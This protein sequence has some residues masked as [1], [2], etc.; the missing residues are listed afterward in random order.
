DLSWFKKTRQ[1]FA[2]ARKGGSEHE[3]T[4]RKRKLT[5]VESEDEEVG[6]VDHSVEVQD[7][8]DG[9][10]AHMSHEDSG[11]ESDFVE[12]NTSADEEVTRESNKQTTS[13]GSR[14]APVEAKKTRGAKAS[15]PEVSQKGRR[16][17]RLAST[18][19]GRSSITASRTGSTTA[20]A[21]VGVR[22]RR[23]GRPMK[24]KRKPRSCHKP[25]SLDSM[26]FYRPSDKNLSTNYNHP[27]DWMHPGTPLRTQNASVQEAIN[28][29]DRELEALEF[30]EEEVPCIRCRNICDPELNLAYDMQGYCRP[31]YVK[32]MYQNP[33]RRPSRSEMLARRR[34]LEKHALSYQID[35]KRQ[36]RS[37]YWCG[38]SLKPFNVDDVAKLEQRSRIDINGQSMP[39]IPFH[40]H[41][42][43]R[44][45][46]AC[47]AELGELL[48]IKRRFQRLYALSSDF[49][50]EQCANCGVRESVKFQPGMDRMGKLCIPCH[51]Y[52]SIHGIERDIYPIS[53]HRMDEFVGAVGENTDDNGIYWDKVACE[54]GV[55]PGFGYSVEGI[56]TQWYNHF[57][58]ADAPPYQTF[59]L[60]Q[61][62]HLAK[63]D[64]DW[65]MY[66]CTAR[67]P[68]QAALYFARFTTLYKKR[69]MTHL[70]IRQVE[71]W[72][73]PKTR[74]DEWEDQSLGLISFDELRRR[75]RNYMN[76]TTDACKSRKLHA[77]HEKLRKLHSDI[78]HQKKRSKEVVDY[79]RSVVPKEDICE[80]GSD[81]I[82][83]DLNRTLYSR[84]LV[85]KRFE[86]G[87]R[88]LHL[89]Q[90]LVWDKE[91]QARE[92][93]RWHREKFYFGHEDL[94]NRLLMELQHLSR[95]P[96][97]IPN[98]HEVVEELYALMERQEFLGETKTWL[99]KRW[100]IQKAILLPFRQEY[101]LWTPREQRDLPEWAKMRRR[102]VDMLLEADELVRAI[103][104][105]KDG[106]NQSKEIKR[107]F[108][109]RIK[110]G[111]T[112]KEPPP[113]ELTYEALAD[114]LQ[115]NALLVN[116][117]P[118]RYEQH[119][120]QKGEEMV[121]LHRTQAQGP[122]LRP[123]MVMDAFPRLP[124]KEKRELSRLMYL[125]QVKEWDEHLAASKPR[126]PV[127]I[128]VAASA[129]AESLSEQRKPLPDPYDMTPTP[130]GDYPVHLLPA[131]YQVHVYR[132]VLNTKTRHVTVRMV[133]T[134]RYKRQGDSIQGGGPVRV[135]P[136][137]N[138]EN[139]RGFYRDMER[140]ACDGQYDSPLLQNRVV[141]KPAAFEAKGAYEAAE[142][143]MRA[144]KPPP[145]LSS[146]S[147]IGRGGEEELESKATRTGVEVHYPIKIEKGR[148]FRHYIH[149]DPAPNPA[150]M[151]RVASRAAGRHGS[152]FMGR[153]PGTPGARPSQGV[154]EK[155]DDNDDDDTEMDDHDKD[156]AAAGNVGIRVRS[157]KEKL[158]RKLARFEQRET[159]EEIEPPSSEDAQA[160]LQFLQHVRALHRWQDDL[161]LEK[162][163]TQQG[164][165]DADQMLRRALRREMQNVA[166]DSD[167]E[168]EEG[169][170]HVN[171][172][173]YYRADGLDEE[174]EEGEEDENEDEILNDQL[175]EEQD[176]EEDEDDEEEEILDDQ[177]DAEQDQENEDEEDIEE[178]EE[179]EEEEEEEL[180]LNRPSLKRT[181]RSSSTLSNSQ[182][183][184]SKR[185]RR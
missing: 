45:C 178:G 110:E 77:E 68:A 32:V 39:S 119:K 65:N 174:L 16:S 105:K 164:G 33:V 75:I 144:N 115:D 37:C 140:T 25:A 72:N 49:F 87:P 6:S 182:Q 20:A 54:E 52:K 92:L 127:A 23:P 81:K 100:K 60:L 58:P 79:V 80:E 148:E 169:E 120:I 180:I 1:G 136:T 122:I 21:A 22:G 35:Y 93:F 11:N 141:V 184:P 51:T 123:T 158:Q 62:N 83:W 154:G 151:D 111:L 43:A 3:R 36:P 155:D 31:C 44:I 48:Q 5:H 42:Q 172:S 133:R 13:G 129:N 98:M 159:V 90:H 70:Y 91:E 67:H 183:S 59:M 84:W 149:P 12:E 147:V 24:L 14:Q 88:N 40:D 64:D 86:V 30:V 38:L 96:Y 28:S 4:G 19:S 85:R 165:L 71:P 78:K 153:V 157:S 162:L 177:L 8:A 167:D 132:A 161:D 17:V 116:Q 117:T 124:I 34:E 7:E 47:A 41:N 135:P 170:D 106:L 181:T 139:M 173:N 176:Q 175:E 69:P 137:I 156:N 55:N 118:E 63:R 125:Q 113:P 15:K 99:N 94:Y 171:W 114:E 112:S 103:V 185:A 128:S 130:P 150:T 26:A 9:S 131:E 29:I 108:N 143:V 97:K 168:A 101:D 18:T 134:E 27:Y 82:K 57:K 95:R 10:L 121:G 66:F 145:S 160:Q 74:G 126:L 152:G 73:I 104:E 61:P 2:S 109:N 107:E 142:V 76:N 102:K 53:H 146:A 179:E 163:M 50:D 138:V 89:L 56:H 166:Y 46:L